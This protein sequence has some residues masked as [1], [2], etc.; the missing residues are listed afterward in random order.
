MRV[1]RTPAIA[2]VSLPRR[3]WLLRASLAALIALTAGLFPVAAHAQDW[4][5]Q[6]RFDASVRSEPFTGRVYLM[7]SPTGEPRRSMNW[8]SPPPMIALDVEHLSPGEVVTF[9]PPFEAPVLTNPRHVDPESL[10]GMSAQAVMRFNPLQRTVGTGAGNGFSQVVQLSRGPGNYTFDV[11]SLVAEQPLEENRWTKL[12]RLKSPLLSEFH[13]REVMMQAAVQLP[14]SYHDSPQKKFPVIYEIQ[15]FGGTLD[16]AMADR[17]HSHPGTDQVEFIHVTL[18]ANCPL[19]HHTFA[20]SA[21]NGPVGQALV[22]EFIPHLESKFRMTGKPY[23][24][25]LTGH[26][27]GGWSSLW[28]QVTYPEVFGGVWSTA[29]DPV[30]FRDFQK[31]D[32]YA[33]GENMY[34]DRA[35][36]RRPLARMRGMAVLWYDAFCRMEDVLGPGGQL[37]SFEAVFSPRGPDGRPLLLWDR[38]TGEIDSAVAE[39]WRAYDIRLILEENWKTLGP[40]LTRKLHVHMGT[41]DTFLLEGATELLKK[42]LEKLGSDAVV[43]MHPG[44]D[45]STLMTPDLIRRIGSEMKVAY[46]VGDASEPR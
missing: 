17:P 42:S 20:D 24:R 41:E 32:L 2:V 6:V 28:L 43:V 40:K 35:G 16:H 39:A 21:N 15:G 5:F 8:F 22:S 44:K 38:E 12:A 46:E 27:S 18:D 13:G 4:E 19:G 7:F 37:H 29:P 34:H 3:D 10:K 25:L 30:D 45:H 26:S 23:G 36:Q 1:R 9:R 33:A 14:P 11:R 31:I